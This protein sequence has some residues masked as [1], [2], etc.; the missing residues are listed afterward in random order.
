MHFEQ[1]CGIG[2]FFEA[3]HRILVASQGILEE[4]LTEEED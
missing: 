2:H 3:I 1:V 4:I